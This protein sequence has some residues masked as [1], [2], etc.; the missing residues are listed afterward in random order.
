MAKEVR[1]K[2]NFRENGNMTAN[3]ADDERL[4]S[5]F[6]N[7]YEIHTDNYEDL[8]NKPSINRVTV[9]G[10]KLGADYRLQDKMDIITEQMI[11]NLFY[12]RT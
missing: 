11:D 1:I 8:Y 12:G 5:S 6:E 3:F 4:K 9:Q 10:D 7:A 2:A